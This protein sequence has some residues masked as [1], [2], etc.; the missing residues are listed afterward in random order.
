MRYV[1]RYLLP[2]ALAYALPYLLAL[3]SLYVSCMR[4]AL[5]AIYILTRARGRVIQI[6]M[7]ANCHSC[8]LRSR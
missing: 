7:N 1:L 6:A 5:R 4:Y 8:S 3:A 2:L